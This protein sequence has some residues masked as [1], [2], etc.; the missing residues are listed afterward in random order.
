M[1]ELQTLV[2]RLQHGNCENVPIFFVQNL[3]KFDERCRKMKKMENNKYKKS[4]NICN[5]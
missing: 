1:L 5:L 4:Q 2:L 3:P